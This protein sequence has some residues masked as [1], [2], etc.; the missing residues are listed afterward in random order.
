MMEPN[1]ARQWAGIASHILAGE[2]I[3]M[4]PEWAEWMYSTFYWVDQ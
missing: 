4:G 1:A 3:P 2:H